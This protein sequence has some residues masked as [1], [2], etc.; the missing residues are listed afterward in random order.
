MTRRTL[1]GSIGLAAASCALRARDNHHEWKPLL[2][3]LGPYTPN[4]VAW[5]KAQGFTNMILGSGPHSTL[6]ANTLTDSQID[7]IKT[8]LQTN[9]MHVSALQVGG[10]SINPNLAQRTRSNNYFIKA[11]EL[12]GKL[13]IPYI[14]T[15]SGRD[16]S[17]PFQKLTVRTWRPVPPA[18]P[19]SLKA[20]A[21][22]RTSACNTIPRTCCGNLWTRF[23]PPAISS[24][25]FTMCI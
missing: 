3:V 15:Q 10:D 14:G 4:N 6:D 8:V 2:G 18:F 5:T 23:K 25:K 16:R 9:E 7:A 13:G 17:K 19:R 1:V 11:I 12:A 20:S 21:I 24:T 22:H